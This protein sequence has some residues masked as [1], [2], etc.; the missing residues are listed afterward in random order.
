MK[1]EDQCVSLELAK[2]LKELRVKQKS[3]FWWMSFR[4]ESSPKDQWSNIY[5]ILMDLDEK[6]SHKELSYLK[7]KKSYSAFTVAEF[8]E[9]LPAKLNQHLSCVKL[10]SVW[11]VTYGLNEKQFGSPKEADARAHMLIYL[12]ENKLMEPPK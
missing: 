6:R 8:G 9:M 4:N 7:D 11:E 5:N 3:Y 12:I 10:N 2:R 1:I